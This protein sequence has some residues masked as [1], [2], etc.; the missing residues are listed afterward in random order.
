MMEKEGLPIFSVVIPTYNRCR[1]LQEALASVYA[2]EGAG[3]L[4]ELEI[5]VVDDGSS[6]DTQLV[7][8]QY[9]DVNYIRLDKNHGQYGAVNIGIKASKGEY[10]ALLDDDDLW[11]PHRLKAHLPVLLKQPEVGAVYG[12]IEATGEDGP[13]VQLWPKVERSPSGNIFATML[14]EELVLPMCV[15]IRRSSFEKAGYFDDKLRTMGHYEMFLRL[16][17]YV[18]Y[19]FVPGPIAIGRF[20]ADAKW[21]SNVKS[22]RYV[23]NTLFIVERMLKEV[24]D[25]VQRTELRRQAHISWRGQFNFWLHKAGQIN[26]IQNLVI[27]AIQEEPWMVS[28]PKALHVLKG[29]MLIVARSLASH[30][31]TPVTD[32]RFLCQQVEKAISKSCGPGKWRQIAEI[33]AAVWMAA[34]VTLAESDNPE[35]GRKGG[36]AVFYALIN[37]PMLITRRAVFKVILCS[38]ITSS[39][40]NAM[41]GIVKKKL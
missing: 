36:A 29:G 13:E 7:M 6:D 28:D 38:I 37:N 39:N 20:S 24:K 4:F 15:I 40:Y 34:S 41:L 14:M 26:Q 3:E 11:L 32:I 35:H 1:V 19:A 18:P 30:S 25:P 23:I 21:F 8:E 17:F 5:V 9:P 12:Q 31:D 2:Q 22:G 16:S 10:I 33:K 27:S